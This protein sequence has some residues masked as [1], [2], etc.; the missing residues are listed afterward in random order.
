MRR[1]VCRIFGHK[2]PAWI[3]LE[4]YGIC[5]CLRCRQRVNFGLSHQELWARR[6]RQ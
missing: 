1:L 4:E 6:E 3:A 2:Y 5:T